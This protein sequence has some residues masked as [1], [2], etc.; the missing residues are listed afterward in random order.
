M[1]LAIAGSDTLWTVMPFRLALSGIFVRTPS[2][3]ALLRV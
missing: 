2:M 1:A 3:G